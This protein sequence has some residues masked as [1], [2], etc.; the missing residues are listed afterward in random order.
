MQ[1]VYHGRQLP[2]ELTSQLVWFQMPSK[3]G[4][5]SRLGP[6]ST[7]GL[8][9]SIDRLAAKLETAGQSAWTKSRLFVDV[10]PRWGKVRNEQFR[11]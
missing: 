4:V 9:W 8:A 11:G 5:S 10:L 7:F 1:N 6:S 2:A 3:F